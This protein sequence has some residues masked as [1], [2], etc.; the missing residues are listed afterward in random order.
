MIHVDNNSTD[1]IDKW[2]KERIDA[3][4]DK[5]H[6]IKR[7]ELHSPGGNRNAGIKLAVELGCSHIILT[8]EDVILHRDCID[9]LITIHEQKSFLLTA[10]VCL[11]PYNLPEAFSKAT[12]P[13]RDLLGVDFEQWTT[14]VQARKT[15]PTLEK[16]L[17]NLTD[18]IMTELD[19]VPVQ[20]VYDAPFPEV[21][22]IRRDF[23]DSVGYYDEGYTVGDV[24]DQDLIHRCHLFSGRPETVSVDWE[25]R[26]A[27]S[28]QLSI[29]FHWGGG[30][31]INNEI[32]WRKINQTL[33]DVNY[34][35]YR[36]KWGGDLN[37]ETWRSPK[38]QPNLWNTEYTFQKLMEKTMNVG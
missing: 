17:L 30:S 27:W 12:K 20:E 3:E 32:D 16:Q 10:A 21:A 13:I 28:S 25:N 19:A 34:E 5:W 29:F 18:A 1:G 6:Y 7:T 15:S 24:E 26:K 9:N 33:L 14:I 35:R 4:P 2:I 37:A 8:E 38:P 31:M 23:V 36:Q 11:S 22:C